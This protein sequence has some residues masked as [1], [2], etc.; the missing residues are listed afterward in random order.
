MITD[1]TPTVEE[2]AQLIPSR[3]AGRFTGGATTAPS[4]PDKPRVQA[5][6]DD[7]VG[8]IAAAVGGDGLDPL[9]HAGAKALVKIQAAV[10]LEPSAWPEQARPDK[11]AFDQWIE[12]LKTSKEDL[13]AAIVR[14]R[15]D[16]DEGP[17][18]SQTV[19]AA[20]PPPGLN[21]PSQEEW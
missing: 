16:Q 8:L 7:A 2:V 3:A 13:V 15:D 11:S 17:G 18:S 10:L 9:F 5:V 14:F 12:M 20:F 1:Y 21:R 19:I 6:I 4:F